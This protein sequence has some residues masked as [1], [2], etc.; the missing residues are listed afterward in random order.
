M[1]QASMP[2]NQEIMTAV[3]TLSGSIKDIADTLNFFMQ[4]TSDNFVK[5][6]GRMDSLESRMD[7]LEKR[8]DSLEDRMDSLEQRVGDVEHRLRDVEIEVFQLKESVRSIS[9]EQKAQR[10]DAKNIFD[11][12]VMLE[13]SS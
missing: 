4:Q 9:N 5:L 3:Q 12:L 11:R 10:N 1:T 7:N 6:W 13:N 2:T 8:M